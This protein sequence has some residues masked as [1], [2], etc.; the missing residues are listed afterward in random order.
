[1]SEFREL[2]LRKYYCK[3]PAAIGA[4]FQKRNGHENLAV[5]SNDWWNNVMTMVKSAYKRL[6]VLRTSTPTA[7]VESQVNNGSAREILLRWLRKLQ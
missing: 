7:K 2:K 3:H 4:V 6:L 1:M 5:P